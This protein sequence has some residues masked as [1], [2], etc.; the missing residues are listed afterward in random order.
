[1][2]KYS[3]YEGYIEILPTERIPEFDCHC[4]ILP[5]LDDGAQTLDD[6][7]YPAGRYLNKIQGL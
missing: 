5:G 6:S 4:H 2:E 3:R 1:M 7:L